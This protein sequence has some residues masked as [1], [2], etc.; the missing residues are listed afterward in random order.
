MERISC[1]NYLNKYTLLTVTVTTPAEVQWIK[2]NKDQVGYYRVNYPT[3]MWT[4]LSDA[5]KTTRGAF[6]ISDRAHLV[7]DAFALADAGQL[8]YGIALD[9]IKYLEAELDYVPWSVGASR[10]SAIK[11]LLYFTDMYRDFV[12]FARQLLK[13]VYAAVTW[14]VQED[15]LRK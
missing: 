4:A 8:D 7:S 9:L 11:N 5:L 12:D 2:F 1:L 3:E 15:H 10:L 6:S 14:N 13:N